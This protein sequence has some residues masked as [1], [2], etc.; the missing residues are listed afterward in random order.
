MYII[1][2][3]PSISRCQVQVWN[4]PMVFLFASKKLLRKFKCINVNVC[5]G[6]FGA[7]TQKLVSLLEPA[8]VEVGSPRIICI[9]LYSWRQ[10]STY[11]DKCTY[12][13]LVNIYIKYLLDFEYVYIYTYTSEQKICILWTILPSLICLHVTRIW[14]Y[15][16]TLR[17]VTLHYTLHCIHTLHAL[18]TVHTLH[19]LHTLQTL[20]T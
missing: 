2:I 6:C 17:C 16:H 5:L 7:D 3:F 18:H 14:T 19:T 20:H 8:S 13:P 1:N 12:L 15:I 9:Y 11:I 4:Y 10:L